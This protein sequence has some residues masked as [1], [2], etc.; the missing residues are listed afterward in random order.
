MYPTAIP[1]L[2]AQVPPDQPL[3]QLFNQELHG[4]PTALPWAVRI[5]PAHRPVDTP[6]VGLYHPTFLY[7][8]LWC[9]AAAAL[10]VWAD[11]RFRLTRGRLFALYVAVYT[12]GRAWI[13]A[14][15]V[16]H[17]NHVLGLRL[18]TWTCLVVS[19]CPAATG[20]PCRALVKTNDSTL[21]GSLIR[22]GPVA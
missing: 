14:L 1:R 12:V 10:L 8:S 6:D 2:S 15:R 4:A 7:E 16:D 17:A 19:R 5:D 13:E 9:L 3:G 11:R 21:W 22:C 18:N 20:A